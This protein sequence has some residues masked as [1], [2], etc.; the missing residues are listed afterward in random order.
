MPE[1]LRIDR[2]FTTEGTDPYDTIEWS[3][4]DSRI[5]NPDGSVVFEMTGAEIP[6]AWSQVAADI[7]VSKYFRK[8][9][10]PQYDEEGNPILD[11]NG[12]PVTGPERS[13]RQV[14]DRLAGTWRWWGERYG[15]FASTADAEAF[16][17]ELKYMLATQMAAPNSPQWFNTG[18][19]HA[20]GLTG[21]AQGFWYVD[22]ETGEMKES[23]DSYS[24]PAP[25]ACFPAG[26]EVMTAE[27]SKPIEKIEPGDLVLTHR[28]R[29]RRVVGTMQR[30][31][32]EDLVRLRI[33]KLT[34]ADFVATE[35]HP[36]LAVK[37]EEARRRFRGHEPTARWVSAGELEP[38][39]Y[40]V[41]ARPPSKGIIPPPVD[42][43]QYCGSNFEITE[44][45]II[46]RNSPHR[47]TMRRFV[48]FD[49][50]AT[51]RLFGRWLG[52]GSISHESRDGS[53]AGVNF[54]FNSNDTASIED[55]AEQ[56]LRV[57]G[58]SANVEYAK[59]QSTAHLR[60]TRRPLARW[61]F[62]SFG[63]GF[64]GKTVPGW[65]YDL[66]R[67]HRMQFLAGLFAADGC[68][69]DQGNSKS[70][71]FDHSNRALAE[72][73]WRLARSLGYA[74]ALIGGTVRPGGTVPHYRV[75]ISTKDAVELAQVCGVELPGGDT[76][77]RELRLGDEV[78]YRVRS[79]EREP[80]F[81]TVYNFQVEEDESYV[82]NGV[83]VHNCFILG[84]KDD[85]V[86]P[87]GIMDLWVREARIFKFGSGAGSNFSAIRAENELLSGGGKSSGVMSF[88]K[89]GDRA[90]G[91]IKSG[92]TTRRAA[93]MVIL[94]VD[95]PDIEA[96]VEWKKVEEEKAKILIE[97]GG[98][99]SD[100]NGEAYAT[101]S[102]QN[103]NNSVRVTR[104]FLQAV[105]DD[106]DWPLIE[107]TT[108]RIRKTIKARELWHR[109]ADAAW[110]CA[111]PGLQFDT[112]INEWHTCP[113]GGRIRASNPCFTGDTR[114]ATD[115]G[116]IPFK[117]LVQRVADGESFQ[118][119]TH[120]AT[121]DEAP[122]ETIDLTS[123]TQV[124]VTGTNQILRL[125]FS[126]GRVLRCT[127]N[128]RLWTANRGWVRADELTDDDQ[129]RLLDRKIDFGM[130]SWAI[131]VSSDPKAYQRRS[132]RRYPV[133][134]PHKWSEELAHYLGWL[135]GDG[136]ITDKA[137]VTVYGTEEE[138]QTAMIMH[139][140]YLAI[141]NGG[142]APKP[143]R[144]A[145]GTYQ[146]RVTRGAIRSFFE[147]LG[148]SRARSADKRIPWSIFE[149]PKPIVAA[150]LRGLYDADGC[151]RYGDT[152][153]YVGLGS[154]S[155][156]LLRD[157]QQLLDTF[158][159]H[160]SIYGVRKTQS[161]AFTYVTKNGDHRT[162]DGHQGFDLR[163]IGRDLERFFDGIGFGLAYKDDILHQML[164]E[165]T[166]YRT[167]HWVKLKNRR[168][169]G[170]E[171][172]YNL[173][174]PKNH[175]YL[176][177]GVLVSNCSE[178]VFL[179]D[180]ACNLASLNLVK[181][182]DDET[183]TFDID[184]Y[185]HAIR[186]WTIVLEISVAMAHFPSK[187]IA[188]GSFD[189]RTLGLGYA[190]L[191][192]L[193]MRQ[194]IAYDSGEG[195]ALA[196]AL[197]AILTGTAYATSA[198]MASVVGPFP[199]FAENREHMLRVIRNHR[200]AAYDASPEEYEG[201]SHRV[202]GIDPALTPPDLLEAARR[203]WDEALALGERHGYRNAQAT[204][205]APT[206]CLVGGSLVPTER[207]LVR[208]RSLGDPEGPRWQHLGI[209][210]ATDEGPKEATRFYVNGVEPVVTVDT[211]RGYR[212][213]GTPTHRIKVV[214][215]ESGQWVWRRFGEIR[216]DD[217][218]PLQMNQLIGTPNEVQLPP[219]G[220]MRGTGDLITTVPR[221]MNA[222]LAELVGYFMS[223]GSLHSKGLRFSVAAGDFEVVE[224]LRILGKELFGLEALVTERGGYTEVAFDSVALTLWWEACG[225]AETAPT[226]NP[227]GTGYAPHIPDA[228][229]HTNDPEVYR[230]FIRGLFEAGGHAH[231]GGYVSWSTT[232]PE[233]SRD[234]QSLLLALGFPTTRR[235]DDPEWGSTPVAELR[236][237]DPA[238]SA[239]W[240]SEVGF[241]SGRK[242]AA[243][244][245][246]DPQAAGEDHIP[247][248]RSMIDRL[249][250][251]G[252]LRK[253]MLQSLSRIGMV[254]RPSAEEL[255]ER[256]ADPELGRLLG[257]FYD[258]VVSAELG[259]EQLT[260]DLSVPENVTYVANGFV[261]HNTIGLLMDC[262]TT[263]VE[264]D[265]ALVKF[266]KLAG[267][268]YFKIVNQSVTP[269]LRHLG[270]TD[271]QIADIVTY[272][273]G[274][275]SL[276]G[277]PHINRVT[278][279]AKGLT[280]A[281]LDR[282]EK[283][284][285]GV[286][287]L[288]HAFNV[289]TLG[290]DT[291]RRLGFS[292]EDYL[293]P[294][295]DLLAALGFSAEQILAANDHICGRQT[296]EGAPHLAPE[297]LS[298]FDTANKNGRYGERFIHYAGHIKMMAAAQPFISGAISKTINMPN[299]ATTDDIEDA[300]RMS[301][302]LGLKAM[303][304]Y[305]DGSKA[306]QPLS[307]TSEEADDEEEESAEMTAAIQ[308][309]KDIAWG[310]IPAG[311]SPTQ[312][313]AAGMAP[314]RFLLPARRHGW[315]QEARIGGHKVF[316]RTGEYE[317]GTLGEIFIDLAKEGATLRGVLASFAIAVSKGLQFGV[318]L[319]EFVDTFNFQTFEPRGMV[320][321]HPNI[322][323]ANSIIDYVFR[324]LA[325]E[326]LHRDDLAQVPPNREG[327][328]PEP[329][330]GIAVEAGVQLNLD[331]ADAEAAVDAVREAAEFAD[332]PV[333][334]GPG[335]P[336][337]QPA[338]A[339]VGANGSNGNGTAAATTASTQAALGEMMGD[340]PLCPTC[341][342]ITI[343]N[344]TCY[345]CLNCGD[346]TGCS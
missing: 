111:D 186:L 210:V 241:V 251:D 330:K 335:T 104:E 187:E 322:K 198:E 11:E 211:A 345:K 149:A 21:P 206:G 229:L 209:D 299:E 51:F 304:L 98:F 107:R 92:G 214:D 207:G 294:G 168:E 319:E 218:V 52:D 222:E 117:R 171:T 116:L 312:A 6:A 328:L 324:A 121:N 266:K 120:D 32:D 174:E 84:V 123:P 227:V 200:R 12:D 77:A 76:S 181:F 295:F 29:Y 213:Q 233:F 202:M 252:D 25:H 296:I 141:L 95:H 97:Y 220:E 310:R 317:D 34:A 125:E 339:P 247:V 54:V 182:Y 313:Y 283:V 166:R 146:L 279:A 167:R 245:T 325:I 23:P 74:P 55:V 73:V 262:D 191:G 239:R 42:L 109:I 38:G 278:L 261:S 184:A 69:L 94:D 49:D 150:F 267:G 342:H 223:D 287:E 75:Q 103:S 79:V 152:T 336:A 248:P 96:F 87:G 158:G 33:S 274:T 144:M 60:Y 305:R 272:I 66:P 65:I 226:E 234:V 242:Q 292:E 160:G 196:G 129:I 165:T 217:L 265:F 39:D 290:E 155:Q 24:R 112:T 308:T 190:N 139:R 276:D 172:T 137:A 72:A 337:A 269:A 170:W 132:S 219:L 301:A 153:R 48:E 260:Y 316:L 238:H 18:L 289:Y 115:K 71:C 88:L 62:D 189:Y 293:S 89:I 246:P 101:V 268:G 53:L 178:Y 232:S 164:V 271:D 16:E 27:G 93:K 86:N 288:R 100:F 270:Y 9:G 321:G 343:R 315:T 4:R 230:G 205:L 157:V 143:T 286:F 199:R 91:A 344:G 338:P 224:W 263:G 15:Y 99:P 43:A 257:F 122:S 162:Y 20:Y 231:P 147:A 254:S 57:F 127:P 346:T 177:G 45:S 14:F 204:V 81:G 282:L 105:Y 331:D 161:R 291:L 61:F 333:S 253:R 41:V 56:M 281:D 59:G 306:S 36:V 329:P 300:Y 142:V 195:R 332:S 8:A 216:P 63:E 179:D 47:P 225:F 326:Y 243:L 70:L 40:V 133:R 201:I 1:G 135:V 193:L 255:F 67:D 148:V 173:T 106:G 180:T 169:D 119:Y 145:N 136:C 188:L 307:A 83:A 285:P 113:E 277:A 259:E 236:L 297:H 102:G 5:T 130:A 80:Y 311:I 2:R 320:E 85:L 185:R 82:A 273:G 175:S 228:V 327:T 134:L 110:A 318:P 258:R 192:S 314:P 249:A 264:P 35:N 90:A 159:V 17:D 26:A 212:I 78:A 244:A 176:A 124:M 334:I 114:V 302:E 323:M 250:P 303:A 118:V 37:A 156:D 183:G 58:V 131:P 240:A 126:D 197:T 151:V 275:S 31:V 64:A 138:Q 46:T 28:G 50:P 154:A 208:L 68:V 3:R 128:H 163:V 44:D 341:G 237:V 140:A 7:M 13:A 309:E 30:H 256:T 284:L 19:H 10:V 340:A 194:G 108:G 22:Q 215:Q 203:S 221:T 280:A 235:L 298:V